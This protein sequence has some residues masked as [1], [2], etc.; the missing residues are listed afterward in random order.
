MGQFILD[1][2]VEI[3]FGLL[4]AGALAFCKYLWS[5]GKNYKKMLKVKEKEDLDHEIDKRIDDVRGEI[6]ELRSYIRSVGQTEKCHM[7]LIISSYKFRLV[8]L[9]REFIKQG[10]MTQPQYDQLV[11]FY[12]LYEGL[13]GNGQAKE[14]YE[15]AMQLD[16]KKSE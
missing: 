5:E 3:L 8:Q 12:R 16:V 2:L 10:Y 14:Y 1:H 15:R 9:C 4:A 11:E 6:E 7:D 13:G